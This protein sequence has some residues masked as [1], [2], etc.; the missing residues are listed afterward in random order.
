MTKRIWNSQIAERVVVHGENREL[1]FFSLGGC[2]RPPLGLLMIQRV[3]RVATQCTGPRLADQ[4]CLAW[5][6]GW[7]M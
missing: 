4:C 6:E 7:G 1:L 2:R 3:R 5:R